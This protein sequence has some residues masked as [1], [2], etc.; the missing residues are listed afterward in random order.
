MPVLDGIEATTQLCANGSGAKVVFLTIHDR[1]EFVR[2]GFAAG[3]LGYV[4]KSY[5][6]SDLVP[7]IHEILAGNRFISPTLH[8]PDIHPTKEHKV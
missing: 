2:A 6:T 1:A 4:V 7:A 3:A 5:L 8:F